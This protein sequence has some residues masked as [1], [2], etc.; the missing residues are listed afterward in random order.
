MVLLMWKIVVLAAMEICSIGCHGRLVLAVMDG[1]NGYC[2]RSK[3]W[4][5]SRKAIMSA[6]CI[7]ECWRP[8]SWKAI[9][10][11]VMEGYSVSRHGR[12]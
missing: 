10:A 1:Y 2:H 11:A 6:V 8:L 4:L 9:M 3:K 7:M 12:L 5:L